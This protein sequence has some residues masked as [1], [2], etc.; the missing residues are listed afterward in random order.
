MN[1]H[2]WPLARQLGA[3]VLL[4]SVIV[5]TVLVVA[6]NVLSNR[7]ALKQAEQQLSRQISA[8]AVSLRDV[9]DAAQDV[10]A[11]RRDMYKKHLPGPLTVGSDT[12]PAGDLP[13]VP[14]MRAGTVA[15]NN[16]LELLGRIRDLIGADPAVMVRQGDKFIRVATFLKNKDGKSQVGV[17]LETDGPETKSLN[18]G[19]PY[20]GMV[21]R[22]G[23][24]YIS[25]FEPVLQN[26]QVVGAISVRV[27]INAIVKRLSESVRAIK[28]G[29]TGYAYVALPGKTFEESSLLVHPTFGGK[30]LA[31]AN[32]P[33]ISSI[34]KRLFEVRNGTIVYDWTDEKTG[35]SGEKLVAVA[36][37]RGTDWTVAAGSW[38]DEFT[39]DA[40]QLRNI[41]IA[42]LVT[43]ALLLVGIVGY[44]TTR[45]LAPIGQMVES[46]QAMG[47]GDLTQHFP[48]ADATSRNEIDRL[49]GSLETMRSDIAGIIGQIS[50]SAREMSSA[51][52]AMTQGA[53]T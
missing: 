28:V 29:E 47:N 30:T 13:A 46:V 42:A 24:F 48:A 39:G 4:I 41:M 31:E 43:A 34:V 8:I 14:V 44:F 52:V 10:A 11:I 38:V 15:L 7:T 25:I 12:A 51:S 37:V 20:F 50:S 16:N 32:N 26:Q 19:K 27:D 2:N 45:R 22:N 18:E 33:Q 21:N 49:N 6:L 53:Q 9:L 35:H 40:R 17:P 36:T 5:F 3:I 1:L 23:V